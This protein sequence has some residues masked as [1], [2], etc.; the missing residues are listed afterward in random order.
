MSSIQGFIWGTSALVIAVNESE[1]GPV[2]AFGG[3]TGGLLLF[4]GG[5]GAKLVAGA[6]R[7]RGACFLIGGG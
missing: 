1:G 5:G 2:I 3:K 7:G 6:K 4:F